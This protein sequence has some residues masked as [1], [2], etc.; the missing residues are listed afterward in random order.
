M[1]ETKSQGC[2]PVMADIMTVNSER[3]ICSR[4]QREFSKRFNAQRHLQQ[5]QPCTIVDPGPERSIWDNS[6]KR[7]RPL[8]PEERKLRKKHQNRAYYQRFVTDPAFV[9]SNVL[10]G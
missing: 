4:C 5:R 6:L 2:V 3:H 10:T 8:T 1:A 9:T 7:M